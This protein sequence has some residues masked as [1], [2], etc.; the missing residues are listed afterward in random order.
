MPKAIMQLPYLFGLKKKKKEKRDIDCVDEKKRK[1]KLVLNVGLSTYHF[2]K[3]YS[4]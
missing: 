1:K 3:S 4:Y 2:V